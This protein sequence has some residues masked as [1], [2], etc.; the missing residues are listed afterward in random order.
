MSSDYVFFRLDS[1][2]GANVT[3]INLLPFNALPVAMQLDIV[4]FVALGERLPVGT[5]PSFEVE[6]RTGFSLQENPAM[7]NPFYYMRDP[8]VLTTL[9][10]HV[11]GKLYKRAELSF[12]VA[13]DAGFERS[14]RQY[15]DVKDSKSTFSSFAESGPFTPELFWKQSQVDPSYFVGALFPLFAVNAKTY[16]DDL[17]EKNP[18]LKDDLATLKYQRLSSHVARISLTTAELRAASMRGVKNI[19][20]PMDLVIP[21]SGN[22]VV[23][24][25][26]KDAGVQMNTDELSAYEYVDVRYGDRGLSHEQLLLKGEII[27]LR[28]NINVGVMFGKEDVAFFYSRA[29]HAWAS[30][31]VNRLQRAS[32]GNSV[33][34]IASEDPS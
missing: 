3:Q 31:V 12:L 10:T 14:L 19:I 33:T 8:I 28:G 24:G 9:D 22:L 34:V 20:S 4:N 30:E 6:C 29:G 23:A 17:F 26:Y 21:T 25:K 18:N 5:L 7:F 15:F 32:D 27:L 2:N 16:F 13:Q 11:L 1:K